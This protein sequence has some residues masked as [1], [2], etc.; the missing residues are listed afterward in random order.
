M[1]QEFPTLS[2]EISKIYNEVDRH[3]PEKRV[4]QRGIINVQCLH[5]NIEMKQRLARWACHEQFENSDR[6]G[7]LNDVCTHL[8]PCNDLSTL[9]PK[10]KNNVIKYYV[11]CD[12]E[13]VLMVPK[14][15]HMPEWRG[16]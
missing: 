10:K 1:Y 16:S 13:F 6:L 2:F 12:K 9:N 15:K 3:L 7:V 8:L 4:K 14:L 5:H 11:K